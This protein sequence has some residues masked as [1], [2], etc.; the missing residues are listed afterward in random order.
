MTFPCNKITF[1][2]HR[3]DHI[4]KSCYFLTEII[5]NHFK[6]SFLDLAW[7]SFTYDIA[8]P[9][10]HPY[11]VTLKWLYLKDIFLFQIRLTYFK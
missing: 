5:F 2:L 6:L 7:S 4:F 1:E 8:V 10:K 9:Y 11:N 3:K